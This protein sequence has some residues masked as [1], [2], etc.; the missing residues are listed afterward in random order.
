MSI[1]DDQQACGQ[2]SEEEEEIS[3]TEIFGGC[4]TLL[5]SSTGD[6][7]ST[8]TFTARV[9]DYRAPTFSVFALADG[10]IWAVAADEEWRL[11]IFGK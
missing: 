6:G 7:L 10:T 8:T 5:Y 11:K 1:L 3:A 2:T 9:F 4:W